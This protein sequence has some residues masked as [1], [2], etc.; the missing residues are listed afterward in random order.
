MQEPILQAR[1][2]TVRFGGVVALDGLSF[3]VDPGEVCAVI[4]PNGAG[5]TLFSTA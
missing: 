2:L 4:G 1:D 5:K 3:S